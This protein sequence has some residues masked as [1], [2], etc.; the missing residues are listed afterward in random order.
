MS[1]DT[2]LNDPNL[3]TLKECSSFETEQLKA[4]AMMKDNLPDYIVESF[5]EAGFDTLDVIAEIDTENTNFTL[6][7]IE[8]FITREFMQDVRFQHSV[9]VTGHFKFLPGHQ[10]QVNNFIKKVKEEVAN[11]TMQQFACIIQLNYIC[12]KSIHLFKCLV[13]N[14]IFQ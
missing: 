5:I 6:E 4:L 3:S 9:S 12:L 14:I 8:Q 11:N 2:E 1:Q 10:R 13:S 7:E